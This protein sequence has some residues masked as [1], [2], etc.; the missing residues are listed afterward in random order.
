MMENLCEWR[1]HYAILSFLRIFPP[2]LYKVEL[3]S[4]RNYRSPVPLR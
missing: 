2:I 1:F 4:E 3:S